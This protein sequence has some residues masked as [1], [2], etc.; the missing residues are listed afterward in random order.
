MMKV[1]EKPLNDNQLSYYS[2]NMPFF[3]YFSGATLKR[4]IL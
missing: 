2:K 3:I 4:T 1:K